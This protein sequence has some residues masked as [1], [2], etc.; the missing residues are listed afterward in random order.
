VKKKI[1]G[2]NTHTSNDND[3]CYKVSD[4]RLLQ[5]EIQRK[6]DS[7]GTLDSAMRKG[8]DS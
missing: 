5:Q 2:N 1:N 4:T 7:Y 8:T 6:I 3:Q